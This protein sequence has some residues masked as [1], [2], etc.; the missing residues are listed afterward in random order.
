[1][2]IKFKQSLKWFAQSK[3]FPYWV[4]P[5]APIPTSTVQKVSDKYYHVLQLE[6]LQST[7]KFEEHANMKKK[8]QLLAA[9]NTNYGQAVEPIRDYLS[10]TAMKTL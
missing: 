4:F 6:N 8:V 5:S 7:G 10:F 3:S 2:G 9:I 1:M